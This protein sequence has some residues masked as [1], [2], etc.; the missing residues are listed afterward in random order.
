M[1]PSVS[2]GYETT[3]DNETAETAYNAA[4]EGGTEMRVSK[5]FKML[6]GRAVKVGSAPEASWSM[7]GTARADGKTHL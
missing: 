4:F 1:V 7:L 5:R 2:Q 6:I 3:S